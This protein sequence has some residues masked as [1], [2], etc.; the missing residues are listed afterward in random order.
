MTE[1]GQPSLINKISPKTPKREGG[2]PNSRTISSP[3]PM[4]SSIKSSTVKPA[5]GIDT[6][7]ISVRPVKST[8][9]PPPM[10]ITQRA[11]QMRRHTEF[12]IKLQRLKASQSLKKPVIDLSVFLTAPTPTKPGNVKNRHHRA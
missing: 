1:S 5:P 9:V 12:R 7:I 2:N 8:S 3:S 4:Q 6:K 11:H 10:T